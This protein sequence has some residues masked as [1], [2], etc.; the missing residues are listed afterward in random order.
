MGEG[1][2]RD[3]RF[4]GMPLRK[5]V[6]W[7]FGFLSLEDTIEV[8]TENGYT[9]CVYGIPFKVDPKTIG[10]FTGLSDKNGVPIYEGDILNSKND[11]SD[12]CDVWSYDD[13]RDIVVEWAGYGFCCLNALDEKTSVHHISRIEVIGNIHEGKL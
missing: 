12:G 2:M 10:Q 5:G 3:I 8:P 1:S 7:A 4:R 6:V 9:R 13:H 11:G